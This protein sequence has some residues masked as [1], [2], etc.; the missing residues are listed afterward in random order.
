MA[1]SSG[2][3]PCWELDFKV[4]VSANS[5]PS[6]ASIA[7]CETVEFSFDNGIEEWTPFESEGWVR[8]LMT[9]KSVTITVTGKRNIGDTGNDFV[10]GLSFVNGQDAEHGFKVV[11]A[12]G[13]E[14]TFENAVFNVTSNGGGDATNVA[15]LE[16][17]VM[18]NGKPSIT[19]ASH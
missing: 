15:P 18:S 6:W 13:D 10:C 7:D 2:V 16:F 3:F 5:T 4:D 8:R 12:D 9:A 1:V 14:V 19:L 17:E 11:F